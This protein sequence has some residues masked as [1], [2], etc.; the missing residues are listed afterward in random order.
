MCGIGIGSMFGYG[1]GIGW[2][3]MLGFGILRLLII[4]GIILLIVKM[5]NK[6]RHGSIKHN[7]ESI[8][9][10][11]ERYAMGDISEEEYE[12]KMNLLRG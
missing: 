4:G 10:L 11:K 2:T 8:E 1:R 12:R 7:N 5:I 6:N 9:I 3:W